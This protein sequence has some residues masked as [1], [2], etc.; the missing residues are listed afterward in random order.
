MEFDKVGI[1]GC[2]LMG[3]GI[4]QVAAVGGCEVVCFESDAAALAKLGE[5]LDEL[6]EAA[7]AGAREAEMGDVLFMAVVHASRMGIDAEAALRGANRRFVRRFRHME[8]ALRVREEAL[9]DLD[10]TGKRALWAEA[11]TVVG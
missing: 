4:A 2:G 5:E 3:H 6:R 11:K 1:V 9:A 10:A 8:G 7:T